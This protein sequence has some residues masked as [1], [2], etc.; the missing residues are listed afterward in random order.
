MNCFK[1]V[2]YLSQEVES[3]RRLFNLRIKI[4]SVNT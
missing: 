1:M 4:I 2:K 3:E